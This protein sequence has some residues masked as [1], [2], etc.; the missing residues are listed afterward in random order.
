M[1]PVHAPDLD[2][3]YRQIREDCGLLDRSDRFSLT[4]RGTEAAEFLQGQVTNEIEKLTV[5]DGCYA[6]L[7]NRKGHMQA[8]MRILHARENE[9]WIDTEGPA[10]PGVLKHLSMYKIGRD[11]EVEASDRK[12]ISLVGPGSLQV[13][14]LSPGDEYSSAET[15]LAGTACLVVATNFGLDLLVESD[16]ADAVV[17]EMESHGAVPVSADAVEILRVETGRPRFGFEM[18]EKTMPAEAGIVESA[19]NFTKGCYIGQEPVA[20]LH[21]KGR[22]NRHL[23]GLKLS[24]PVDAGSPV[25]LGDRELGAVGTAVLSPASGQIGMAILRKEAE[26]GATVIV[27]SQGNDVEAQVVDL[28]FIEDPLQ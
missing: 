23:R 11:A 28:P 3:E 12:I 26:P 22:P 5:G 27:S 17:K 9:L 25:H 20:R 16:S 24:G 6:A 10:G 19:V 7:L 2:A 13:V 4:V 8:D 21:Y 14:G 15:T 1:L 18:T